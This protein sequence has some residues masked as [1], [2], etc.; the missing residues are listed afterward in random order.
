MMLVL[1]LP[2]LYLGLVCWW[3]IRAEPKPLEPAVVPVEPIDPA[4]PSRWR[5]GQAAV[6]ATRRLRRAA[7]TPDGPR[8]RERLRRRARPSRT[9]E[10]GR[11]VGGF[12]AAA[13]IALSAVAVV[14][15]LFGWCRLRAG[16]RI[17]R[18]WLDQ[19]ASRAS[20]GIRGGGRRRSLVGGDDHR[21]LDGQTALLTRPHPPG[22]SLIQRTD[23]CTTSMG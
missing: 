13:S 17:R 11:G 18:G 19:R 3:A 10:R 6:P 22:L 2:L 7:R 14:Y 8:C 4:D 21:R 20:G 15:R 16:H 5:R 9:D 12:L 1:K 23:E